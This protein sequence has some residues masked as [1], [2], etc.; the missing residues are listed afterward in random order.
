MQ[1]EIIEIIKKATIVIDT[2]RQLIELYQ[3]QIIDMS[4]TTK[5]EL[6]GDVIA[7]IQRLNTILNENSY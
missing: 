2:Q 7:E 4:M 1:E 5:I 3:S 6:G